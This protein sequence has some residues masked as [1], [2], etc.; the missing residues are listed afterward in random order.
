MDMRKKIMDAAEARMRAFGYNATSFRDVAE[1]VGVRS[2][3]VH[4][5]FPSK[6]DLAEAV[7][8]RYAARGFALLNAATE[9]GATPAHCA[10]AMVD[11]HDSAFIA[12]ESICLCAML[13]A[14]SVG[15]PA[16]VNQ[17]VGVYYDAC[18]AWLQEAFAELGPE[19]AELRAD[20][21][22]SALQGGHILAASARDRAHF[23][24]AAAG[25][26]ALAV[27]AVI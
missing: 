3:S 11:L 6:E 16:R 8:E 27:G 17:A 1:D 7:V 25:A 10:R 12:G 14:E 4:Y 13:S 18:R 19:R 23:E 26:M 5:H 9:G 21:M 22:L 20:A 2:A 24:R 15:L